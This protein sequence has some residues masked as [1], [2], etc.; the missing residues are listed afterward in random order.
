MSLENALDIGTLPVQRRKDMCQLPLNPYVT[1][2]LQ[3][4][5]VKPSDIKSLYKG[6]MKNKMEKLQLLNDLA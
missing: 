1:G 4:L 2:V 3:Y 5:Y 6:N